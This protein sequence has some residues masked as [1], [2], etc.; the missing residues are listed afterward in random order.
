MV[1]DGQVTM[2]EHMM[3]RPK[4]GEAEEQTMR[5]LHC[6]ILKEILLHP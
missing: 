3:R 6:L 1:P 4:S 2:Q 5:M